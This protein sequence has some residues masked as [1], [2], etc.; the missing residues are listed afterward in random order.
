MF[1]LP[2][3]VTEDSELPIPEENAVIKFELQEESS[4]GGSTTSIQ[5]V[6]FGGYTFFKLRVSRNPL[7]SRHSGK[8]SSNDTCTSL[9]MI[10]EQQEEVKPKPL[11]A[12][13]KKRP[14]ED[15]M[16]TEQMNDEDLQSALKQPPEMQT[17]LI[18]D[19]A[20]PLQVFPSKAVKA[21][22]ALPPQDLP[23][24][25]LLTQTLQVQALPSETL[26]SH[27][28]Q[29]YD[30][31]SEDMPSLDTPSQDIQSQDTQ[32]Q[33]IALQ[34]IP[35]QDMPSIGTSSQDTPS[36]DMPSQDILSQNTPSQDMSSKDMLSQVQDLPTGAILFEAQTLHPV[37]FL[38]EKHLE[39]EPPN[40]QLQSTQH[41]EEQFIYVSY[42]SIQSEVNLLT[43][44][45]KYENKLPSRKST[46]RHSFSGHCSQRPKK[47]ASLKKK[48]IDLPIQ[49]QLS[50]RRKSLNQR[51]KTWLF[52]K[53]QSM[54]KHV[55]GEQTIQQ[56]PDQQAE[57]QLAQGEQSLKQ[58]SQNGQ[59]KDEQ[60]KEEQSPKKQ[61]KNGQ[62][63]DQQQTQHQ[64]GGKLQAHKEKFPRQLGQRQQSQLQECQDWQS[65]REQSPD[66]KAQDWH[67]LG[68]QSQGWRNKDYKAQECRLEMLRSLNWG[69]QPGNTQ[70]LLEKESL[71]Q[72]ALYQ[73]PS[74]VH[75]L[76]RYHLGRQLQDVL[77]QDDQYQG[78]DQRDLH[79]TG[80]Q[81]EDRPIDAL[82]TK[83]I[84]LRDMKSLCQNSTDQQS[85]DRKSDFHHSSCESS[86][87]DMYFTYLSNA[88]S[89]HAQQSTSLCSASYKEESALTSCYAKD[90]PSEDSD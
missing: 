7:A 23:P 54:N 8:R 49:G 13:L 46:K 66:L 38:N 19:E 74:T 43:Q 50:P 34:G 29:S 11:P 79:S 56:L 4:S 86:E 17:Q 9:S 27:V 89:V 51:I 37:Q 44:E 6:F 25:A 68:Q 72:K 32:S 60:G 35:S 39:Q 41:Q 21:L 48:S 63:R 42:Q 76:S 45:W 55:Q 28:T 90:Q 40:L 57:D 22:E 36:Q 20:L 15:T 1:F 69:F 24:Q 67:S 12:I 73:E 53:R 52:P 87:Q 14:S 64:H 59:G 58:Q 61:S 83:D 71:R 81:R 47:I 18:Q 62:D 3:D 84:N 78:K 33:D 26:T 85:E 75:D 5:P 30:L 65:P 16:H 10:N 2:S 31:I 82:R 77:S 88:N 80:F 70:D